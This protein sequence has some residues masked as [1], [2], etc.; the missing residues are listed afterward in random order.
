M[1]GRRASSVLRWGSPLLSMAPAPWMMSKVCQ[2]G[3]IANAVWLCR[4]AHMNLRKVRFLSLLPGS[5]GDDAM[6]SVTTTRDGAAQ[7]APSSTSVSRYEKCC[8]SVAANHRW[9]DKFGCHDA[10]NQTDLDGTCTKRTWADVSHLA[11]TGLAF[12]SVECR[13]CR[14]FGRTVLER[15]PK[16]AI[17]QYFTNPRGNAARIAQRRPLTGGRYWQSLCQWMSS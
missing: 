7:H 14:H 12:M 15:R 3:P 16:A 4:L 11:I 17:L 5:C 10:Q 2:N 6:R 8:G 13:G 1:R 9:C